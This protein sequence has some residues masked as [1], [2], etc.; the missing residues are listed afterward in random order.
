[1][2]EPL[3]VQTFTFIILVRYDILMAT[4]PINL[5]ANTISIKDTIRR[6]CLPGRYLKALLSSSLR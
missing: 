6:N 1:M 4:K 5:H 2:N 3:V